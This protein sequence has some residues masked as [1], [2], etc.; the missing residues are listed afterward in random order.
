MSRVFI[1]ETIAGSQIK[2]FF[3]GVLNLDSDLRK[4]YP[5][6]CQTMV[7]SRFPSHFCQFGA[8]KGAADLGGIDQSF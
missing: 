4:R 5:A 7:S 1:L 6:D 2:A 3:M 8:V